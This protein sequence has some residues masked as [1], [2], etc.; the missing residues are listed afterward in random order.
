MSGSVGTEAPAGLN[1]GRAIL[2]SIQSHQNKI[3]K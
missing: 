3:N 1:C 2:N